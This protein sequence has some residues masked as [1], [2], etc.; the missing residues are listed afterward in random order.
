[1][2]ELYMHNDII[3]GVMQIESVDVMVFHNFELLRLETYQVPQ[4]CFKAGL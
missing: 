2:F 1:M 4:E 3:R